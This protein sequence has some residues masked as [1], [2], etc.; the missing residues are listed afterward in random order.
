MITWCRLVL[1]VL[2]AP[3]LTTAAT[4]QSVS[5]TTYVGGYGVPGA[6]SLTVLELVDTGGVVSG[7]MQ[8]PYDRAD[9]PPL[10]N[11]ITKGEELTFNVDNL[12]FVL[13]R[14]AYDY[15]GFVRDQKGKG[16]PKAEFI[17]RRT[18]TPHE[19]PTTPTYY[20]GGYGTPGNFVYT[21]I[22]FETGKIRQPFDRTDQ[23]P[24]RNL[25]VRNGQLRFDADRL[26]FEL[27]QFDHGA[28]GWV[29]DAAN[30]AS[31]LTFP[32]TNSGF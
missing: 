13:H 3:S 2:L 12:Y 8:Q 22:S 27:T 16:E 29:V 26:H 23:P 9:A 17:K 21:F 24:L 20:S 11:L 25:T 19:I 15:A 1:I 30:Q 6:F 4:S 5:S 7:K 18:P 31:F 14:T 28:R 10:Q 32:P